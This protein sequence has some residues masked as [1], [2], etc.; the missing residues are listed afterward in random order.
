MGIEGLSDEELLAEAKS[1]LELLP[2]GVPYRIAAS[3]RVDA[4]KMLQYMKKPRLS[5]MFPRTDYAVE[6]ELGTVD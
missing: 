5:F 1:E 3:A 2:P 6:Q 4:A